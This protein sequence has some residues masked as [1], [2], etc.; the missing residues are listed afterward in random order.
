MAASTRKTSKKT[1]QKKA[2][3]AQATASARGT[4]TLPDKPNSVIKNPS[5]AEFEAMQERLEKATKENADW[6]AKYASAMD[7]IANLSEKV[8]R[9]ARALSRLGVGSG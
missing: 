7:R 5:F 9:Q 1:D 8:G 4:I 2:K 3:L 6:Q